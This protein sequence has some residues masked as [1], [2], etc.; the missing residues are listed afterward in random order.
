M[1]LTRFLVRG[2]SPRQFGAQRGTQWP[3]VAIRRFLLYDVFLHELGH[4][5]VVNEKAKDERRKFAM[6]TKAQE[7]S[8]YWCRKLWSEPFDHSDPAHSPPEDD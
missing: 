4:L 6:E 2:Q 5:Q 8:M 1:S 3:K 7:F